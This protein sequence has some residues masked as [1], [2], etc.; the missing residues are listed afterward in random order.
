MKNFAKLVHT[1]YY[2]PSLDSYLGNTYAT[3]TLHT[4][5]VINL[6]SLYGATLTSNNPEY[7]ELTQAFCF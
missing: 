5:N 1:F 3:R 2:N 7:C 6:T 4:H